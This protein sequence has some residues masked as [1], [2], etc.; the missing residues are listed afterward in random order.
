MTTSPPLERVRVRRLA[1]A[2]DQ[3]PFGRGERGHLGAAARLRQRMLGHRRA[4]RVGRGRFSGVM[5]MSESENIAAA[6]EADPG[7]DPTANQ[8]AMDAEDR[9]RPEFV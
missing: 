7:A 3:A 9:L 2:M 1:S 4:A 8:R 6:R 5:R